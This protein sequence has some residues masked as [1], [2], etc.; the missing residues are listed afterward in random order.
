MQYLRVFFY[1]LLFAQVSLTQISTSLAADSDEVVAKLGNTELKQSQ[2]KS[3][4][5]ALEPAARKQL[6][7]DPAAF[8]QAI[9]T[10]IIRR[11][12]LR[13][14]TEKQWEKRPEVQA[15]LDK[16]REQLV[17]S[18]YLN[19]ISRPAANYPS[20]DEVTQTYI[21]NKAT[22]TV[23]KQYH[24]AQIYIARPTEGNADS[25]VKRVNELVAKLKKTDFAEQARKLSEHKESAERG[26]DMGWIAED[27]V[28]PEL[29]ESLPKMQPNEISKPI[30]T[31][32]GWHIVKL[33]ESKPAQLK[34]LS[35]MHD[36]IV[37]NLRLNKAKQA[38]Q[39][40]IEQLL[41]SQKLA[42]NEN[43][44]NTLSKQ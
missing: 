39:Q 22:F 42:I 20:D 6:L 17:V 14:A 1:F 11:A 21:S 43:A 36:I 30:K 32:T 2:V 18:A 26:G 33:L 15:Q 8:S 31:A 24:I 44:V 23:P 40:Y 37:A 16:L 10:E 29:R 28:I 27:Q 7:S 3:L 38:E 4:L 19:N 12:V 5:D 9:Q 13:E 25:T 34:P 41:S 35:E